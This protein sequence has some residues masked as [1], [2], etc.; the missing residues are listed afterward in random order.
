M[1]YS[2]KFDTDFA[3]KVLLFFCVVAVVFGVSEDALASG[4]TTNSGDEIGKKMCALVQSLSG[5]IAKAVA[6]IAIIGVAGG[7]LMG[8]LNWPTALTVCVGV[9]II[10]SAGKIVGWISGTNGVTADGSC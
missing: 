9:I 10:F 2:F 3:W 7:L 4:G 1:T 8:K 6:T 5:G